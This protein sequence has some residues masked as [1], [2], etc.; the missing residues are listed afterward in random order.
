MNEVVDPWPVLPT[1]SQR[2]IRNNDYDHLEYSDDGV[3]CVK[4]AA[5]I[6]NPMSSCG[7]LAARATASSLGSTVLR[8][9]QTHAAAFQLMIITKLT[10]TSTSMP[11]GDV[12]GFPS[13]ASAAYGGPAVLPPPYSMTATDA[14]AG[15]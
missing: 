12:V 7:Q 10:V 2:G 9:R 3:V 8:L 4:K 5:N 15:A 6:L 14:E 1:R 11:I 13:L